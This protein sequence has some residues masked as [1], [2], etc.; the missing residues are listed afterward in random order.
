MARHAF[1]FELGV[2][3]RAAVQLRNWTRNVLLIRENLQKENA[4]AIKIQAI[5]RGFLIRKRLPQIM[6]ELKMQKQMH[7]ATLIQVKFHIIY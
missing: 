6:Y 4:A 3:M 2:E 1:L 7:A 5:V